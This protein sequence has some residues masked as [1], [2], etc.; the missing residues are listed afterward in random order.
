MN[1]A[2]ALL[3]ALQNG[4]GLLAVLVWFAFEVRAL[5]RDFTRH[6]QIFH[7]VK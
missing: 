2:L 6:E 3:G 7:G 1:E 4:G 5:R